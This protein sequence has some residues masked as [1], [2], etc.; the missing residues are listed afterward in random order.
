[1]KKLGVKVSASTHRRSFE[2]ARW[3]IMNRLRASPSWTMFQSFIAPAFENGEYP[4]KHAGKLRK[5][6]LAAEVDPVTVVIRQSK[7]AWFMV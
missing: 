6:K 7:N 2:G 4:E 5:L 3:A 1:M